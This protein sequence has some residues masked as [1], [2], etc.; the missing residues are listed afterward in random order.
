MFD[1]P[2]GNLPVEDIF[3]KTEPAPR[4]GPGAGP[5][6]VPQIPRPGAIR[7]VT[8]GAAAV[9]ESPVSGARRIF[10][11]IGVSAAVVLIFAGVVWGLTSFISKKQAAPP[12]APPAAG[13]ATEANVNLAPPPTAVGAPSAN[14]N[15]PPPAAEPPVI[16]PPANL[17]PPAPV[18]TDTDGDGLTDAEEQSF[19]TDPS[20]TD[21]DGDGLTDF[22]EVRTWQTDPLN[23]DTDGDGYQDGVE[24]KNGYDPKGPGKLLT[25]P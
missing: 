5:P 20:K 8:S 16:T 23:P 19:G 15:L 22:E 21:T 1:Q 14:V 12:P 13:P 18:F 4:T 25:P 9:V 6:A 3:E 17:P 7:P 10:L 11:F 2:P 24:V